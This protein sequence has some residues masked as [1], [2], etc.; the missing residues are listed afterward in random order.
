[1]AHV[2]G[3]FLID[4]CNGVSLVVTE[5]FPLGSLT[6]LW[7]NAMGCSLLVSLASLICL[8]ILP[9]IFCKQLKF[10]MFL[11]LFFKIHCLSYLH[12]ETPNQNDLF[13]AVKGKPSKAVV[14]SLALFGVRM[15][16]YGLEFPEYFPWFVQFLLFLCV[17]VEKIVCGR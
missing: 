4:L 1:M 7:V 13:P 3:S 9:V 17:Q 2:I 14:D 15:I 16:F 6:G 8:I 5:S 11:P 12:F 10:F